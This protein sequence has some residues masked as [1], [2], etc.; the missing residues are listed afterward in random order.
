VDDWEIEFLFDPGVKIFLFS[1]SCTKVVGVCLPRRRIP[2]G[3]S[4]TIKWSRSKD[5]H[6]HSSSEVGN[7][8]WSYSH[9][10]PYAFKM[11]C[12][13]NLKENIPLNLF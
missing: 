8:A 1:V 13:V 12:S 9:S 4:M 3:L 6:L 11:A 10:E 2:K 7:N 5:G